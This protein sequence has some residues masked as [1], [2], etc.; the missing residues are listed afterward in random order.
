M[1]VRPLWMC[2]NYICINTFFTDSL[3]RPIEEKMRTIFLA[4]VVVVEFESPFTV[5]KVDMF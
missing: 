4:E 3:P 2:D 5:Q 1:E